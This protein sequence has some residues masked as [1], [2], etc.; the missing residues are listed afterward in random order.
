MRSL[1]VVPASDAKA[2][3]RT[4]SLK[5]DQIIIDLEDMVT[6]ENKAEARANTKEFLEKSESFKKLSLRVNELGTADAEL[7]I[8]LINSFNPIRISSIVLP[9]INSI[10]DVKYWARKLPSNMQL[11]VQIETAMGL[12]KAAKIASHDQVSSLAFGPADFMG[13]VGIP[14]KG[15]GNPWPEVAG[16]LEYPLFQMIIAAHAHGKLAYDGPYFQTADHLGLTKA[17]YK[18]RALG[19]DGK[20]AIHPDQIYLCNEAFT[21]GE[22]EIADAHRII[23][24][25]AQMQGAAN[26]DGLVVDVATKR[27]AERL[28]ERASFARD[29]T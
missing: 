5:C 1:L 11:E 7:D 2:L 8:E 12:V 16:I 19:A 6:P 20:W 23:E 15:P 18:A 27:A 3:L 22:D 9:K 14:S 10:D 29:I 25:Y 13:S 26:A 4:L 28:L 24:Q 21:P 17:A